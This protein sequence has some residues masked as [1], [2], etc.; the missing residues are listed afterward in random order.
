MP[1]EEEILETANGRIQKHRTG[2]VVV[3]VMDS[4]GSPITGT[5]ITVQQ[6]N[7]ALAPCPWH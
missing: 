6:A 5:E 7:H 2:D 3:R 4:T 1:S